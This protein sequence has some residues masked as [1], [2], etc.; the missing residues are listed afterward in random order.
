MW[1]H[2]RSNPILLGWL[3]TLALIALAVVIVPLARVVAATGLAFIATLTGDQRFRIAAQRAL[4]V[5]LRIALGVAV[6][7]AAVVPAAATPVS[8]HYA[9]SLDRAP[10]PGHAAVDASRPAPAMAQAP[11]VQHTVAASDPY[12]VK[13]G[14]CLWNIAE[15][16]HPDATNADLTRLW[17]QLWQD[18][19]AVIGDDPSI[20]HPGQTLDLEVLA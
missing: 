14:D 7:S 20:I 19:K 2:A 12:V 13:P 6:G 9:I 15:A 10:L 4:P 8:Q 3:G 16:T 5:T 1:E 11:L 17:K 18:N